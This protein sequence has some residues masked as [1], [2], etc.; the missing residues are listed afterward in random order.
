MYEDFPSDMDRKKVLEEEGY[1]IGNSAGQRCNS[2]IESILQA[3]L[4]SVIINI[5]R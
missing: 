4:A 2:L 3:L 5:S 1:A